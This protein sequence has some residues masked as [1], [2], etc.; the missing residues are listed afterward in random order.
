MRLLLDTHI[1]LWAISDDPRLSGA[2]R[3]LITAPE[4][5][6]FVSAA[7]IWE[8]SIKYR[9]GRTN[10]P[11]SGAEA[12]GWFRESGYRLLSISPEHA[13]AVEALAPLHADPFDRMLVAQA[14]YEPLRLVTHDGQVARYSDTIIAV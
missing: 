8:I 3:A 2:A 4:N 10:M 7:S 14:L 11:V 5:E 9:L 6:I 1:A 13:V 12:L